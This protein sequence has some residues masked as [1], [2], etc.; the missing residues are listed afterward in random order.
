[1][2]LTSNVPPL[3]VT[4]TVPIRPE[5]KEI[6]ELSTVNELFWPIVIAVEFCSALATMPPLA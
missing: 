3:N 1:M 5:V 6:N 2:A 4:G